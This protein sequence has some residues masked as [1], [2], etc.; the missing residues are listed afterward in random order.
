MEKKLKEDMK[1]DWKNCACSSKKRV[2]LQRALASAETQF[3]EQLE[4]RQHAKTLSAFSSLRS[5]SFDEAEE[6]VEVSRSHLE[7]NHCVT[8]S[9]LGRL[10]LS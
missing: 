5:T 4:A 8:H 1:D 6:S 2:F 10:L 7:T 3:F 9:Q